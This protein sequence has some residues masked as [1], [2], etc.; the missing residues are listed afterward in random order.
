[1]AVAFG[2]VGT[3]AAAASGTSITPALPAGLAV[4]NLLIGIVATKNNATHTWPAGWTKAAQVNSGASWTVSWAWRIN[5]SGVAAPAVSWTGSV[6]NTGIVFSYTGQDQFGPIG[7][8][9]TAGTGTTSPHTSAA[10]TTTRANSAA[11]YLDA[12]SIATALTTPSGYT[13]HVSSTSATSVTAINS[14]DK[15]VAA[16]GT[17]TGAISTAGGAA[18]WVEWQIEILAPMPPATDVQTIQFPDPH[19]TAQRD[20][21]LRSWELA[22]FYPPS[23]MPGVADY[24]LT[25]APYRIEQTTTWRQVGMLGQDI[26]P[27]RQVYELPPRAAPRLQYYGIEWRQVGMLGRDVL[28]KNQFDW[29]LP[30]RN[31][32]WTQYREWT[33]RQ[34]GMLGQD[35]LPIRQQDWPLP[36]QPARLDQTWIVNLLENTLFVQPAPQGPLGVILN[37]YDWPLPRGPYR[38]EQTWIWNQVPML[39]QDQLL[40][41]Q[42]STELAP[43]APSRLQYYGWEWRQVSMLGQDT[44]PGRQVYDLTPRPAPRSQY[45]GWEW[46]QVGML[47]QD[48]LLAGQQSTDL[49]PK[50]AP[51]SQYYGWEWR[52]VGMLGL[53]R[54]PV[55]QQFTEL[56]PRAPLRGADIETWIQSLNL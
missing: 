45:Y 5:I 13:S 51:R 23:Y 20:K 54:L 21:L 9:G 25:P 22:P 32:W 18:A 1:M 35:Q 36:I 30:Q 38:I 41:G 40:V 4:G 8:V 39:G 7:V 34:V 6:A 15:T 27:G 3:L 33:W 48:Y 14:G 42:Q 56:P 46:R 26:V 37:Q 11:I 12:A 28:P 50:A 31:P 10:I 44:V 53:D 29:P 43:R 19:L 16:Q 52:Q 2:A 49:T 24:P 17:S 47:G 55:G